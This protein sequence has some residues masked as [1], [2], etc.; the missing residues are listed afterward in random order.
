MAEVCRRLD[1][2]PL[3]I[4]LAAAR[5]KVLPPVAL[6]ARL[7]RSLPLL[8]GGPRDLPAR[9]RT[10]RDAIAWSYDLLSADDQALFRCVAVFVGGFTLDTAQWVMG[11]GS[12]DLRS[13]AVE[14]D[15]QSL[16]P[17]T[18]SLSPAI[19]D[20]IASLVEHN[21]LRR[22]GQEAVD[23]RFELL[24]TIREFGLE[25]LAASGEEAV[26]P[27]VA[28]GILPGA[29]GGVCARPARGQGPR[30]MGRP[31][32]CRSGEPPGRAQLVRSNR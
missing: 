32:E 4:E 11:V 2:L 13:D 8:T 12:R 17:I 21:L 25:Q 20:G 23:P 10:M 6:A 31:L 29:D 3:A 15:R 18:A 1:G 27:P 14:P 22:T 7:E 30:Q 5:I 16:L 24:E 19:L 9:Q 28:R 26:H